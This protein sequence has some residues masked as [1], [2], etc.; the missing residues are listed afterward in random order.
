MTFEGETF[1]SFESAKNVIIGEEDNYQWYNRLSGRPIQNPK[2]YKD[3]VLY[4]YNNRM[5]YKGMTRMEKTPRG[6][7][8]TQEAFDQEGY[9]TFDDL[10]YSVT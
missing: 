9:S 4:S 6:V 5:G 3:V 2:K 1:K 8:V 10:W 7:T